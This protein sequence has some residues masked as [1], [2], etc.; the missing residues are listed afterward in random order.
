MTGAARE[1]DQADF[2]LDRF[3]DMY[4]EAMM[5]QDPRVIETLRKLMMIVVLTRPETPAQGHDGYDGGRKTGPLRRLYEDL[6]HL[7]NRMHR[8]DE[9]LSSLKHRMYSDRAATQTYDAWEQV[10]AKQMASQIDADVLKNISRKINGGYT[11]GPE[12][13]TKGLKDA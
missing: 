5:S 10:A 7:N 9:E 13:S 3:I 2:D 1:P 4:D 11:L 6:N 12:T 8:M